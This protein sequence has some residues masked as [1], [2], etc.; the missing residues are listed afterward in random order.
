MPE[1]ERVEG[2][3]G[4]GKCGLK[5]YVNNTKYEYDNRAKEVICAMR[6]GG[7]PGL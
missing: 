6:K 4:V 2:C 1:I 7:E 5:S 3:C